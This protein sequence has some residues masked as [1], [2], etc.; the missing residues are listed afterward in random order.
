MVLIS[1]LK[2]RKNVSLISKTLSRP[3]KL[4]WRNVKTILTSR[5]TRLP[6]T[7]SKSKSKSKPGEKRKTKKSVRFH[8]D[9]GNIL[10]LPSVPRESPQLKSIE[11]RFK[12][13]F[14][15]SPEKITKV[16]FIQEEF[17]TQTEKRRRLSNPKLKVPTHSPS[18]KKSPKKR[19][20][21]KKNAVKVKA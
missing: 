13:V 19:T 20:S 14:G 10:N 6:R 3:I 17:I 12:E 4:T 1:S 16:D 2:T 8:T 15:K 5:L 11:E 21:K 9:K 7:K 18:P